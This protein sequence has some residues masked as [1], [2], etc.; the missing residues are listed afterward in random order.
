[1]TYLYIYVRTAL[2][3]GIPFYIY[4]SVFEYTDRLS[5][6]LLLESCVY[7]CVCIYQNAQNKRHI[8]KSKTIQD[9][10]SPIQCIQLRM[11]FECN[12]NK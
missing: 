6:F 7:V 8:K 2:F 11:A 10:P 1:M 9:R 12:N 4:C 3:I 5:L